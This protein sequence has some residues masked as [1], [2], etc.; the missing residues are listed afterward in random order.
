MTEADVR[1]LSRS[2]KDGTTVVV[3]AR[4]GSTYA[5]SPVTLRIDTAGGRLVGEVVMRLSLG[6]TE[7][8]DFG[9]IAQVRVGDLEQQQQL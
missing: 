5:G 2:L 6:T 9:E 1:R 8:V 7:L 4:D 3:L